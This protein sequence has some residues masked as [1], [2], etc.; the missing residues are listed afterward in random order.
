MTRDD[1]EA[2]ADTAR[3]S[4]QPLVVFPEGHRTRDGEIRPFKRT[5]V[6]AI[7]HGRPWTVYVLVVDGLWSC[8]QLSDFVRGVSSVRARLES[9]GPFEFP[10]PGGDAD[11]FLEDVRAHM[12]SKLREIR[13]S[14]G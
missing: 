8:A 2:L 5:G 4:E 7:L 10:G 12:T 14:G 9:L 6:R 1:V 11:A 13:G 3:T